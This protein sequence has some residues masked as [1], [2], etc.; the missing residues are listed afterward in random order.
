LAQHRLAT[1]LDDAT[2]VRLRRHVD[3][4]L[5]ADRL[6]SRAGTVPVDQA[7]PE[8]VHRLLAGETV[9]AGD[10]GLHLTRALVEAGVVVAG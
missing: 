1:S 5:E 9:R 10:L 8:L 2:P 6:T 4:R 7:P 3:A